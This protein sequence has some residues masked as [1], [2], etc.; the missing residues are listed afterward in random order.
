[1]CQYTIQATYEADKGTN[2]ARYDSDKVLDKIRLGQDTTQARY[3]ESV[4]IQPGQ[5]LSQVRYD[6]CNVVYG[7]RRVRQGTT[8][9][10][11]V[12]CYSSDV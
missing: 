1:M 4:K 5:C 7:Y 9:I 8:Q 6:S 10:S 12:K 11:Q 2:N 3:N